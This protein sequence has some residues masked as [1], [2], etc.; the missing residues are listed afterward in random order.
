MSHALTASTSRRPSPADSPDLAQ[1]LTQKR[2]EIDEEVERFRAKKTQEFQDFEHALRQKGGL[3]DRARGGAGSSASP[4]SA[5]KSLLGLLA[6]TQ[7]GNTRGKLEKHNRNDHIQNGRAS[8]DTCNGSSSKL[9]TPNRPGL[10]VYQLDGTKEEDDHISREE[11]FQASESLSHRIHD[12]VFSLENEH[13]ITSDQPTSGN[14]KAS[15]PSDKFTVTSPRNSTVSSEPVTISS[16][17]ILIHHTS[18]SSSTPLTWNHTPLGLSPPNYLHLLESKHSSLPRDSDKHSYTATNQTSSPSRCP[19]QPSTSLPS[20]FRR[21][22]SS[23]SRTPKHVLFKLADTAIV[24]PS[25]S[26]EERPSMSSPN[27]GP[28]PLSDR[29]RKDGDIDVPTT[30]RT[31]RSKPSQKPK[32][33]TREWAAKKKEEDDAEDGMFQLDE[34]VDRRDDS[35]HADGEDPE[36]STPTSSSHSHHHDEEDEDLTVGSPAAGSLPIN[37]VKTR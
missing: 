29:L 3:H 4:A 2:A 23:I 15:S 5:R 36:P 19:S 7:L 14:S 11:P 30:T 16:S 13:Y 33:E 21:R 32:A 9:H 10:D 24:E 28:S 1:I 18:T 35:S 8:Y 27:N 37:I 31:N 22:S 26:Y 17:T 6:D 25:S 20:A 34:D 12:S